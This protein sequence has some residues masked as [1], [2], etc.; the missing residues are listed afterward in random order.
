MCVGFTGTNFA[1]AALPP[2]AAAV[3]QSKMRI[4]RTASAKKH[5]KRFHCIC[6]VAIWLLNR[7]GNLPLDVSLSKLR[8]FFSLVLDALISDFYHSAPLTDRPSIL[9]P[10]NIALDGEGEYYNCLGILRLL[11]VLRPFLITSLPDSGGSQWC[12]SPYSLFY[13]L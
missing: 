12:F 1:Q 2:Y 3:L 4:R 6:D 13:L 10:K 8:E 11:W 7:Q 5:T 9:E